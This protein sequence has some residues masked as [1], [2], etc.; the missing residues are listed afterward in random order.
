MVLDHGSVT[1]ATSQAATHEG[2]IMKILWATLVIAAISL[3]LLTAKDRHARTLPSTRSIEQQ[4]RD[5]AIVRVHW[6]DRHAELDR[7]Q[8]RKTLQIK[9][10]VPGTSGTTTLVHI[11]FEITTTS[12]GITKTTKLIGYQQDPVHNKDIAVWYFPELG[13]FVYFDDDTHKLIHDTIV[14]NH[15]RQRQQEQQHKQEQPEIRFAI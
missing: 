12:Y 2:Q 4:L 6:T 15:R 11:V 3:V 9:A 1:N 5:A 8:F 13:G 7:N 10:F 14:E